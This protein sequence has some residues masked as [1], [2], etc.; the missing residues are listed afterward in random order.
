MQIASTES[1]APQARR[2]ADQSN[3]RR[4]ELVAPQTFL[5]ILET[6]PTLP[7]LRDGG[8][9]SQMEANVQADER[10][11][12]RRHANAYGDNANDVARQ[13]ERQGDAGSRTA[14]RAQLR[15]IARERAQ[16]PEH[17]PAKGDARQPAAKEAVAAQT[18]GQRGDAPTETRR[19]AQT[20]NSAEAAS[21][22]GRAAAHTG[23]RTTTGP[24][25]AAQPAAQQQTGPR[26]PLAV[27]APQPVLGSLTPAGSQGES[28][29]SAVSAVGNV[30]RS[31]PSGRIAGGAGADSGGASRHAFAAARHHAASGETARG[32]RFGQLA[33]KSNE[34]ATS[35]EREANIARLLKS[36]H[37][38]IRGEKSVTT[39]RLNPQEL[40]SL[41]VQLT[42]QQQTLVL[43][44]DTQTD[45]AHRMLR[46]ELDSLR[47]GLEAAGI[48]LERAEIRPPEASHAAADQRFDE[49]PTEDSSARPR[50][51]DA[52]GEERSTGAQTERA[53][54]GAAAG[55]DAGWGDL[56]APSAPHEQTPATESRVNLVA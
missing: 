5:T 21:T 34:G 36:I 10:L 11:S 42:M 7:T 35:A 1:A 43:R 30:E 32:V 51:R 22:E 45:L 46:E 41:R 17:K 15:E 44:V 3:E 52:S 16:T 50:Q 40:G 25:P 8:F 47:H 55:M 37:S 27:A 24:S 9:A 56:E 48:R 31:G 28:R 38:Q 18:A 39:M 23:Q 26:A 2:P 49:A 29:S 54:D 53:A 12:A 20:Q 19:G 4:G 13:A 33:S 6:V 14:Q